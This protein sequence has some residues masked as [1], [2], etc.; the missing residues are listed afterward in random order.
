MRF[1]SKVGGFFQSHLKIA[2]SFPPFVHI[3][4]IAYKMINKKHLVGIKDKYPAPAPTP[5]KFKLLVVVPPTWSEV[6]K[7]WGP[8]VG[9]FYYDI[10]K[11]AQERYGSSYVDYIELGSDRRDWS[12]FLLNKIV[13]SK[14]SH[15]IFHA[16]EIPYGDLA[17]LLKFGQ[18]L[19]SCFSGALTL[20]MYDSIFWNHLFIAESV[21]KV[22]SGTCILAT[23]QFPRLA[24]V[25]AKM[26]PALLPTS[27]ESVK[28]LDAEYAKQTQHPKFGTTIIGSVYGYRER[29][30]KTL[31][32][33]GINVEVNPH[34]TPAS[35]NT[36]SY[37]DF[38]S[39]LR[40][41][42]F[43]LNFSRANGALVRHAKTRLLEATLFGTIVA[44][45][46]KRITSC[47]LH[48]SEYIFFRNPRNLQKKINYL[49][50]NQQEYES[51]LKKS[52]E[53]GARL[54][55]AFWV[56]FEDLTALHF[57]HLP[58]PPEPLIEISRVKY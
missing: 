12:N 50:E 25:N 9:H 33:L 7:G 45:D 43:T 54:R 24:K 56:A 8:G 53:A 2:Q 39:V 37:L 15:I 3:A 34:K 6:K 42:K 20:L 21:Q 14:P 23:D 41:S 51:L 31:S 13:D 58:A 32:R 40:N 5:Q 16:E 18:D 48:E 28:F 35:R 27:L 57:S 47:L 46:E 38:Y 44:T 22:F 4:R 49:Y 1:L 10:W 52:S 29:K 36:S 30:L 26:G 55:S 11:A 19:N 17:Q